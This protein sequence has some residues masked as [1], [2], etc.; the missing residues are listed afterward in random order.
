[1]PAGTK[2]VGSDC[3]DDL[4]GQE[5]DRRQTILELEFEGLTQAIK[6]ECSRNVVLM[7]GQN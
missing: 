5:F 2:L 6:H 7:L 3:F 1:M 4:V